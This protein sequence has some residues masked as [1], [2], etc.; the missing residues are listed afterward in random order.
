MIK[1]L[2][3]NDFQMLEGVNMFKL[4]KKGTK[5]DFY[6]LMMIFLLCLLR[7]TLSL[8]WTLDTHEQMIINGITSTLILV[9]VLFVLKKKINNQHELNIKEDLLKGLLQESRTTLGKIIGNTQDA[10]IKEPA[11]QLSEAIENIGT[12]NRVKSDTSYQPEKLLRRAKINRNLRKGIVAILI[13]LMIGSLVIYTEMVVELVESKMYRAI[14]VY[15]SESSK[16]ILGKDSYIFLVDEKGAVL[17]HP[18]SEYYMINI[19]ETEYLK[20]YL[21]GKPT[22]ITDYTGNWSV[23]LCKKI[24]PM[25]ILPL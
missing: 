22:F 14:D 13:V 20:P 7:T 25:N 23:C 6:I 12:F 18:N 16:N 4:L 8:Y 3:I 17:D 2:K 5:S 19:K 15:S 24:L 10:K 9:I 11:M 21:S 1:R